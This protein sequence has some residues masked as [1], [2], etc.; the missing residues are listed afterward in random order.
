MIFDPCELAAF[1][2][3]FALANLLHVLVRFLESRRPR[4]E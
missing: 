3:G 2:F 4:D 1:A